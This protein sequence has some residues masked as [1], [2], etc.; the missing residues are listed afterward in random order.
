MKQKVIH[1]KYEN[2]QSWYVKILLTVCVL[3][4]AVGIY[5]HPV[6][7]A[8]TKI[9]A[10]KAGKTYKYDLNG[11]NKK[12]K[13]LVKVQNKAAYQKANIYIN[14]QFL[15]TR[16][17]ERYADRTT[18]YIHLIDLDSKDKYK[19]LHLVQKQ[20]TQGECLSDACIYRYNG[21]KLKLYGCIGAPGYEWTELKSTQPGNGTIVY[22]TART[23]EFPFDLMY[24]DVYKIDGTNFKPTS[25]IYKATAESKKIEYKAIREM[26]ARKSRGSGG[27]VFTV[28]KG[29]KVTVEKVSDYKSK[30]YVYIKNQ[31]GEK[32]WIQLKVQNDLDLYFEEEEEEATIFLNKTKATIYTS[33]KKTVQLKA[34]VTGASSKVTWK[35]SD[36]K[37]ATVNGK[38]LVTAK[39][40]G[41]VAITAKANG[42][43]VKCKVTVKTK[44][45]DENEIYKQY[46]ANSKATL[47]DGTTL[48]LKDAYFTVAD[49]DGNGTLELLIREGEDAYGN[50]SVVRIFTILNSKI[51]YAGAIAN[52]GHEPQISKYGGIHNTWFAA[53]CANFYIDTIKNGTLYKKVAITKYTEPGFTQYYSFDASWKRTY[54]TKTQYETTLNKYEKS[55]TSGPAFRKNNASN[56][57]VVFG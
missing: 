27:I 8:G 12:E 42:L 9:I 24:E 20:E 32:G 19:E 13:I 16:T 17:W 51:K 25:D 47:S 40:A 56:R 7:A 48:N 30:H 21:K 33:G 29:S 57:T 3:L 49:I 14:N 10:L 6:S 1:T 45:L 11:D 18:I 39:K 36:K 31:N 52:V 34:T 2:V 35:S 55:L 26:K 5:S 15:A 23:Y 54:I 44:T 43:T 53:G 41:T 38:G 37:I 22:T 50:Q 4:C 46:L 28:P